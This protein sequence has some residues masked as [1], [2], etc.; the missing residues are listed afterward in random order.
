MGSEDATDADDTLIF[1]P[2]ETHRF[3]EHYTDYTGAGT[4]AVRPPKHGSAG[5]YVFLERR[6]RAISRNSGKLAKINLC[7]SLTLS[8]P[9]T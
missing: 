5:H 3:S 2:A 9:L 6:C 1:A 7:V 8:K 4:A